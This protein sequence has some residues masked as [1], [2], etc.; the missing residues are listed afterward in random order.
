MKNKLLCLGLTSLFL[1]GCSKKAEVIDY[2]SIKNKI[3]NKEDFIFT[4]SNENC[5]NCINL[6]KNYNKSKYTNTYFYIDLNKIDEGIDKNDEES[7]GNIFS[8]LKFFII[9]C[10]F[11][12]F[13][14]IKICF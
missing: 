14:D 6:K 13:L 2:E 5:S 8:D 12:T 11:L 9:I 1:F 7:I 4:I 3:E 10:I